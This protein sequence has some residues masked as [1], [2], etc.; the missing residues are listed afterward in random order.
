MNS[1]NASYSLFGWDF[2]INA[3]IYIFLNNI[4]DIERITEKEILEAVEISKNVFV[5]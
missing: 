3:A 4:K 2:Q 5:V 1:R